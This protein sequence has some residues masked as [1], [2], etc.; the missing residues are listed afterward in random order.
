MKR[1]TTL[2]LFLIAAF[3]GFA[4]GWKPVGA[5]A[6]GL[7]NTSVCLDD[8]WAYHHNPGALARIKHFSGGAYY[9]ARFLAKELQTQGIVVAMPLKK[10]VISVGGQFSGY[11]Q[12]RHTRAGVGYSL[13]LSEKIGAGV[14]ANMQQLRFG[15]NYGSSI[16]ATFEGGILAQLSEKWKL[17]ASVLNIGRQRIAP[18]EEDRFTSVIRIGSTYQPSKKVNVLLEVEKQ[19]IHSISF[20]GGIEYMPV[21]MLVIRF[22]AQSGPT[23]FALGVGYRKNGFLLD[24]AT[25]YHPVLGWTPA[26]GFTYQPW[27]AQ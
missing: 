22:G 25:K 4:Q 24:L 11:E 2:L 5:R 12:Y 18:L 7:A 20:R 14:Q 9:E 21:E 1:T 23:E 27:D 3:H 13:Q 8:V 15:G 19:V 17:G 10:G 26:I 16:N 6:A